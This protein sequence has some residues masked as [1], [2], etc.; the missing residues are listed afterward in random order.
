LRTL[1]LTVGALTAF[2][3]NSLLCRAALGSFAI[4]PLSFTTLRIASGTA[5]LAVISALTA[6][7]A[8]ITP[9]RGVASVAALFVY[10]TGFSLA[11]IDLGAGTGALILFGSVQ[12]TMLLT[13]IH[14]GERPTAR[15]WIGLS[16][17]ALGLVLL[18]LPGLSA[19]SPLGAALMAIAG[20][21]WG[22]YSL[23]GRRGQSALADTSRNF[24]YCVPLA[25][26][27]SALTLR[28]AHLTMPGVLLAL[29]SGIAASGLGY[30][31]WY[32]ALKS[33]SATRAAT[34]QLAVPPLAAFGGVL[35]LD[36]AVTLRLSATAVL[37]LGGIALAVLGR[38]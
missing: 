9:H 24:L 36:E 4:D 34:V 21:G 1:L 27:L 22:V 13:A 17:A 28:N 33:L 30:V 23:L 12:L 2:A 18:V 19:P 20:V 31:I 26:L 14:S 7:R 16:L 32:A 5:V 29:S 10:M 8:R 6:E 11:Y 3:A 38:R 35:L 15:E 37:I 25:V